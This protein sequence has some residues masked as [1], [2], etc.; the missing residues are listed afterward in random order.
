MTNY[1][2][3]KKLLG[4]IDPVGDSSVDEKRY[5]NLE[6]TIDVVNQL[7]FDIN[8]V[9]GNADRQEH[10]MQKAGKK[11]QSFLKEV[12]EEFASNN[13]QAIFE[14]LIKNGDAGSE[15]LHAWFLAERHVIKQKIV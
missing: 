3:L 7:L 12:N 6:A 9:A 13:I 10:S 2:V 11:A 15:Q 1:D 8:H 5:K 14:E 4:P